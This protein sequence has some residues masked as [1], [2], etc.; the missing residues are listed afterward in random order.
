MVKTIS[1]KLYTTGIISY[2]IL[3]MLEFFLILYILFVFV[4]P[5]PLLGITLGIAIIYFLYRKCL[6]LQNQPVEGKNILVLAFLTQTANL[7]C[8]LLLSLALAAGVHLLIVENRYL[9]LFNFV[10]ALLISIRWF[11][12]TH[13]IFR[14]FVEKWLIERPSDVFAVCFGLRK[15]GVVGMTPVFMDAGYLCDSG[16]FFE[17]VFSKQ[18]S[19]MFSLVEKISSEKIRITFTNPSPPFYADAL[20]IVLKN[21]RYP[22]MSRQTR[23]TIFRSLEKRQ[24][25]QP[26]I[27]PTS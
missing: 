14:H 2:K 6:L 11:D 4:F 7:I 3:H 12:F 26:G 22:F 16:D 5:L 15:K 19:N 25:A 20:L 18:W 21:Y 10:F 24:Q 9:F 17:G 27:R 8:C 1:L 13:R 23:D